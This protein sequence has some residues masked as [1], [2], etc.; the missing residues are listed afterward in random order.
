M[1]THAQATQLTPDST[2]ERLEALAREYA[3]LMAKYEKLTGRMDEVKGE[4]RR[5]LDYGT[6]THAGLRISV[7]HNPRF[8]RD[9]F[10]AA[11]PA[12]RH[13]HLYQPAQPLM[14]AVRTYLPPAEVKGFEDEGTPKIVVQ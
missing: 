9:A 12:A 8:N 6:H 5:L 3:D 1:H 4:W 7:Q 14:A 10:M 13:P 2:E 11:Y